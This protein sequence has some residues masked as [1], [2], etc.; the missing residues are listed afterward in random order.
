MSVYPPKNNPYDSALQYFAWKTADGTAGTQFHWFSSPSQVQTPYLSPI[1]G[2]ITLSNSH[3][4]TR[5]SGESN[6]KVKR[7]MSAGGRRQTNPSFRNINEASFWVA[8]IASFN[9]RSTVH[10][11]ILDRHHEFVQCR[12]LRRDRKSTRLNSSHLGI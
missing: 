7:A 5:V 11:I 1:D 4:S 9:A 12:T 2:P 3:S 8:V 10:L 6:S